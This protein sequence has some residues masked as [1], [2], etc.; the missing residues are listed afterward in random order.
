MLSSDT[1]KLNGKSTNDVVA[2]S[3][4]NKPKIYENLDNKN[5]AENHKKIMIEHKKKKL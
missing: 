1:R 3:R 2:K 5:R 4:K